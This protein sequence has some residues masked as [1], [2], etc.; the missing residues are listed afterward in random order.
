MKLL[1]SVLSAALAVNAYVKVD[2]D[3]LPNHSEAGQF[4]TNRCGTRDSKN[5]KCQNVWVNSAE[6]SVR[7]G[8]DIDL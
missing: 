7:A 5:S 8:L 4:G 6:E 1:L 2:P 3:N